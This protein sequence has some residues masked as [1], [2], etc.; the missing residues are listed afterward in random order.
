M[1]VGCTFYTQLV[2]KKNCRNSV[3]PAK[4]VSTILCQ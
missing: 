4:W 2:R 3:F 1:D